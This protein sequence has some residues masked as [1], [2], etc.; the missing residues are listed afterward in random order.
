LIYTKGHCEKEQS[1]TSKVTVIKVSPRYFDAEDLA[2]SIAKAVEFISGKDIKGRA[3]YN[4]SSDSY[5]ISLEWDEEESDR[6]TW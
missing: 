5:D 2:F 3:F 6:V 1:V 4:I